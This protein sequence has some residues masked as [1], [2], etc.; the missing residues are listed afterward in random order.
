MSTNDVIKDDFKDFFRCTGRKKDYIGYLIVIKTRGLKNCRLQISRSSQFD[1][2]IDP[3][4]GIVKVKFR[5]SYYNEYKLS[6]GD[7]GNFD[8]LIILGLNKDKKTIEKVFAIP[9]KELKGK[10]FITITNTGQM[11]Q[12]F[13]IDERPY[14]RVYD[15]MKTGKYSIE[16]D[17]DITIVPIIH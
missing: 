12:K 17:G 2:L 9:E 4:Y 15:Y 16:E 11:Y 7:G 10:R 8:T 5:T 6:L 3:E 1:E 13:R 14:R